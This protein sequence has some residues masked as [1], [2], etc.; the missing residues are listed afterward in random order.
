MGQQSIEDILNA[1]VCMIP[2]AHWAA[3]LSVFVQ[4]LPASSLEMSSTAKGGPCA[5]AAPEVY[6]HVTAM[7]GFA[8]SDHTHEAVGNQ[9]LWA[10]RCRLLLQ[11]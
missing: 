3:A 7:Y 6:S 5:A 8:R 9:V 2:A 10:G 11:V 4:R 1:T